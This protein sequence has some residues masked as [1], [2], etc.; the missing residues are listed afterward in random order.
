MRYCLIPLLTCCF[1][2]ASAADEASMV[3]FT[4]PD[5]ARSL[6]R[7][8]GSLYG[9]LWQE[10]RLAELR[11]RVSNAVAPAERSLGMSLTEAL[12]ACRAIDAR[13]GTIIPGPRVT[14]PWFAGRGDFGPLAITL[15][16]LVRE[17]KNPGTAVTIPG[18]DEAIQAPAEKNGFRPTLARFG[19]R[20]VIATGDVAV[21]AARPA[22]VPGDADLLM[23]VDYSAF[24]DAVRNSP[25]PETAK[26]LANIPEQ[27]RSFLGPIRWEVTLVAEGLRERIVQQSEQP[28]ALAADRS[29]LAHLPANT[30]L[31]GV[32]GF[33]S[34]AWWRMVEPMVLSTAKTNGQDLT[35]DQLHT[36]VDK[37]LAGAGLPI[38]FAEL[39]DSIKGSLL[40]A[41]TPGSPFPAVTIAI[42]RSRAVDELLVFGAKQLMQEL[43]VEGAVANLAL[44]NLPLPISLLAD[45]THWI[46]TTDALVASGWSAPP[47]ADHF[48]TTPAAKLALEKAPADAW[49]IGA[50]ATPAVIRTLAGF[51]PLIPGGEDPKAKQLIT[52]LVARLAGLASTGYVFGRVG[53]GRNEFEAR[54]VLGMGVIPLIAAIAIPNLLESRVTSNEAAAAASLKS[55]VFPAQIQFQ[56]GSY[57]DQDGDGIG[58]FGFLTELAGGPVVGQKDELV[59]SLMTADFKAPTPERAGYRYIVYLPDGQ[60]GALTA[61]PGARPKNVA[62]A[63]E[64][65]KHFVAYAWPAS[66]ESGRRIFAITEEGI[67]RAS[68]PGPAPAEAP[69]WN[70]LSGGK[71]WEDPPAWEPHKKR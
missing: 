33:D 62:A 12:R 6:Q 21:E 34:A 49:L 32:L 37:G 40:I 7:W 11:T 3:T 27:F 66:S 24:I 8:E 70:A 9:K 63:K 42:P 10:P 46:A 4:L 43:P 52:V 55:G 53:G 26:K 58:E 28:G 38:G 31:A 71:G 44:P 30:L 17:D 64:Q 29:L 45:K 5:G 22:V 15:M 65:A 61:A 16:R 41:V 25:D 47:A 1:G 18:A 68:K 59:L 56:I 23:T 36:E 67:V 48:G 13:I 39:V 60:G 19:E 51:I 54:G 69:P 20:L 57:A 35:P 2:I 50:S 14:P